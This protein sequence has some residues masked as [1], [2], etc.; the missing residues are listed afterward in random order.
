MKVI[1][2]ST[3]VSL[4]LPVALSNTG[5]DT[6]QT[7]LLWNLNPKKCTWKCGSNIRSSINIM[8]AA[9]TQHRTAFIDSIRWLRVKRND[10][11]TFRSV[12]NT[13]T[14]IIRSLLPAQWNRFHISKYCSSSSSQKEI[15]K[16]FNSFCWL[17]NWC[18]PFQ[19]TSFERSHKGIS[20]EREWKQISC[21]RTHHQNENCSPKSTR[22]S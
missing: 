15:Y 4:E 10:C 22:G 21:T 20:S 18:S 13:H 8:F 19:C 2:K 16:Y 12:W 9:Q 14:I 7:S 3:R 1:K 17:L 5:N 11:F 6:Q